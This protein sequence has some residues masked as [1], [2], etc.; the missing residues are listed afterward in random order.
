MSRPVAFAILALSLLVAGCAQTTQ[1][2]VSGEECTAA[3]PVLG[4]N[5]A[6]C[7]PPAVPAG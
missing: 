6:D 2:P 5:A 4:M 7:V 1:Y 3:D